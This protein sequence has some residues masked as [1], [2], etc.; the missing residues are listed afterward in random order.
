MYNILLFVQDT[1]IQSEFVS[2]NMFSFKAHVMKHENH[3][4]L[5]SA[6]WQ[7]IKIIGKSK[8]IFAS[9]IIFVVMG[10]TPAPDQY[11][12]ELTKKLK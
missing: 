3:I 8:P 12:W 6:K 7:A 1:Q 5:T 9:T 11:Y 4:I 10:N 2:I